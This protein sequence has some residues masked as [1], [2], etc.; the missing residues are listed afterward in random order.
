M[1]AYVYVHVGVVMHGC[2]SA[3]ASMRSDCQSGLATVSDEYHAQ[4]PT[5]PPMACRQ[6]IWQEA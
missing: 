4:K 5:S 1:D 3:A 2:Y 6:D